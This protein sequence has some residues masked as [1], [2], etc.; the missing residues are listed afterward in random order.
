[1]RR[2]GFSTII[3]LTLLLGLVTTLGAESTKPSGQGSTQGSTPPARLYTEDEA[4]AAARAAAQTAVDVAVPLA[5]QAAVA[6]KEGERA[7]AQALADGY[8]QDSR[9]YR[10]ERTWALI[11]GAAVGALAALAFR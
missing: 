10:S 9:R 4:L 2:L 8:E 3:L 1:M 11:I 6:Q 5:V 7:A